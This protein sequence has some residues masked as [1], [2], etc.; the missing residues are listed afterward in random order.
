VATLDRDARAMSTTAHS[1]LSLR[2]SAALFAVLA[3]TT[4]WT[5]PSPAHSTQSPASVGPSVHA[6]ATIGSQRTA[7]SA[8]A[9]EAR[10]AASWIPSVGQ[11]A[12]SPDAR[13][14]AFSIYKSPPKAPPAAK[15]PAPKEHRVKATTKLSTTKPSTTNSSP[16]AHK[17]LFQGTNHFWIPSLGMSYGV[18]WYACGRTTTPLNHIYRWGCAGR[19]NV[20]LLGHA[21]GVMKP[22]HDLYVRGGLRRGMIAVYADANGHVRKY[23][24]TEWRVVRPTEIAWQIAAQPVPSM[25]LQTCIGANSEYRLNVR[26]VAVN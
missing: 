18:R 4:G 10:R 21:W 19:N 24:V 26:L 14:S 16:I 17:R 7:A 25:T 2:K 15:A 23:A 13:R 6:A 1:R 9:Q 3:I 8:L 22:L 20:Y 12:S 11:P 5:T